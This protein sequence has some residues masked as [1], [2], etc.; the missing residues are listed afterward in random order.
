M[1]LFQVLDTRIALAISK[2]GRWSMIASRS[3]Y[4]RRTAFAAAIFFLV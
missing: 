1:R 2:G 3:S 4:V